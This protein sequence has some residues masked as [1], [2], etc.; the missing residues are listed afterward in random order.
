MNQ[1]RTASYLR[2]KTAIYPHSPADVLGEGRY[3]ETTTLGEDVTQREGYLRFRARALEL[4]RRYL[5]IATGGEIE[6]SDVFD[7]NFDPQEDRDSLAHLLYAS[8]GNVRQLVALLDRSMVIAHR[9]HGG[10]GPVSDK[11]VHECLVARA[12]SLEELHSASERQYLGRIANACRLRRTFMFTF[13]NGARALAKYV[14]RS[15]EGSILTVVP[16]RSRRQGTTYAFDYAYCIAHSIPTHADPA[17]GHPASWIEHTHRI[18][19]PMVD[20]SLLQGRI[21]GEIV[22]TREQA[23]L[24]RG[25]DREDYYFSRESL[26]ESQRDLPAAAGSRVTFIPGELGKTKHAFQVELALHDVIADMSARST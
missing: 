24:I 25:S 12:R 11:H 6:P 20:Q 1:L 13:P 8:E 2:T 14:N 22:Y 17:P 19:A 9:D 26:I 15:E 3:G 21:T 16:S 4:V 23:G 10:S 7:F 18:S 5:N